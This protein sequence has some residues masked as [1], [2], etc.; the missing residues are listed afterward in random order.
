LHCQF[1]RRVDFGVGRLAEFGHNSG[2]RGLCDEAGVGA[3]GAGVFVE[4]VQR[5]GHLLIADIPTRRVSTVSQMAFP[6][7]PESYQAHGRGACSGRAAQSGRTN[8]PREPEVGIAKN[9]TSF[10]AFQNFALWDHLLAEVSTSCG[11]TV[12]CWKNF[13]GGRRHE[14]STFLG[15]NYYGRAAVEPFSGPLGPDQRRFPQTAEAIGIVCDDMFERHPTGFGNL[16]KKFHHRYGLPIYITE[17]GAASTDEDFRIR[18]LSGTFARTAWRD[19]RRRRRARIFLL[20]ADWTISS[21]SSA[22]QKNSACCP[23]IL[24]TKSF[25][26]R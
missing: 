2:V 11:S 8:F 6:F 5:A 14:D 17:H 16:L 20:V 18:D 22:T 26:A 23:W 7:L 1:L 4:H 25:R 24:P 21:G 19:E 13:L 10:G 15:V 12:L 9:W 3:E